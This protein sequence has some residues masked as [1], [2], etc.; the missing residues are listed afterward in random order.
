MQ[1]CD[2]CGL[3]VTS[4]P[5]LPTVQFLHCAKTDA[6]S[7]LNLHRDVVAIDTV[8]QAPAWGQRKYILVYLSCDVS[9]KKL[10]KAWNEARLAAADY[11]VYDIDI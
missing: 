7:N 2:W 10:V 8:L 6:V 4:F 11:I 9:N 1:N 3:A 5:G